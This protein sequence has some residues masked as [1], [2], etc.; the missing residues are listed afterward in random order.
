[1]KNLR[2]RRRWPRKIL[3]APEVCFLDIDTAKRGTEYRL[4]EFRSSL[5]V[6]ICEVSPGGVRIKSEEKIECADLNM[7]VAIKM[8]KHNLAMNPDFLENFWNEAKIIASFN[9]DNIVRVYDIEAL[10]RT[11]F[12]IME[13]LDGETLQDMLIRL[14]SI[15]MRRIID[16]LIQ[17]CCGLG[18][19]HQRHIV[20][21]DIKPAN[22]FV[23]KYGRL[24]ILDFGLACPTCCEDRPFEGTVNYMSPEQASCE[25]TDQRSDIYAL[26]I[27]AYEMVTGQRPYPENDLVNLMKLKV[28]QDIPDP[29][30]MVPDL[31]MELRK[32]IITACRR[33][34]DQ[35]YQNVGQA[36]IDLHQLADKF[37]LK[38]S[39]LSLGKQKMTTLYL[40]YK[41][42][43][44][45]ALGQIV[46][47]FS[48]S[49][50]NPGI[51]QQM[52]SL[53]MDRHKMTT[54]FII[55]KDF[56]QKELY[57][58]IEEFSTKVKEIGVIQKA[59]D[60][61]YV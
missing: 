5:Y 50:E 7:S 53:Q 44:R 23:Q 14:G 39:D 8:M 46:K 6:D 51:I 21:Q 18:Y 9:H 32:F 10:Y 47:D 61:Q 25:L 1:M 26:G 16:Y 3:S 54:I 49:I 34:P 40:M 36:L 4:D 24:K 52:A 60:F 30:E 31:P 29:A 13:H 48:E 22:L 43:Q 2:D 20:H 17:T 15:P 11:V 42:D 19:A 33:N 12:I 38:R 35:R 57:K 58:K 28:D 56:H 55:Y 45:Q 59:S 37:R 41:E 27:T